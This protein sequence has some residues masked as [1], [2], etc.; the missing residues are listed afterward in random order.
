MRVV[1]W[2][3]QILELGNFQL[4]EVLILVI[5][6]LSFSCTTTAKVKDSLSLVIESEIVMKPT[7][8]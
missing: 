5:V 6:R 8:S 7:F 1:G 3:W 4:F 2:G